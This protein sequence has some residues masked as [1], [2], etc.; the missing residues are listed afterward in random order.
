MLRRSSLFSLRGIQRGKVSWSNLFESL[1]TQPLALLA[2]SS[3]YNRDHCFTYR[4]V[5]MAGKTHGS[6]NKV[7]L[8]GISR[9]GRSAMYRRKFMYKRNKVPVK[10]EAK[11]EATFKTK[12]IKGEGNGK[13]RDVLLKKSVSR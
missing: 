11:V 3:Q 2:D 4:R 7:L 13:T 8:G 6:K 10:A 9:Y 1:I 5:K 12:E